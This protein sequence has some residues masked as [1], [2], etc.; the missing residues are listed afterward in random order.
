MLGCYVQKFKKIQNDPAYC[1]YDRSSVIVLATGLCDTGDY[2]DAQ[3][4]VGIKRKENSIYACLCFKAEKLHDTRS[5]RV[6][7]Y[8]DFIAWT[9]G[10]L[11]VYL[12]SIEVDASSWIRRF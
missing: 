10:V 5:M 9:P 6:N 12:S 11:C 1:D 4:V 7:A 3:E 2:G 8:L